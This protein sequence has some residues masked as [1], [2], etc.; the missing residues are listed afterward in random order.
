MI[1]KLKMKGI[2][3]KKEELFGVF[4]RGGYSSKVDFKK[5]FL[6]D[7][8]IRRDNGQGFFILSIIMI[9]KFIKNIKRFL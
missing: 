4:R 5:S 2:G 9:F 6:E 8:R 1:V 3:T 7:L